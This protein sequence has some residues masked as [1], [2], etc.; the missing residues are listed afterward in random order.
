VLK[1]LE[2]RRKR[3][4]VFIFRNIGPEYVFPVGVW[5]VRDCIRDA[6]LQ[7]PEKYGDL[8]S[9]LEQVGEKMGNLSTWKNKSQLLPLI[10]RQQRLVDFYPQAP[11]AATV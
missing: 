9:A 1:Q 10:E 7:K 6:L 8:Q 5:H 11:A 4:A 2:G 3:G